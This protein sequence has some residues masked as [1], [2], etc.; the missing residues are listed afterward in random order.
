MSAGVAPAL[1][2]LGGRERAAL[3]LPVLTLALL[4]VTIG[5]APEPFVAFAERAAGQLLDPTLYVQAVLG[6]GT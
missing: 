1:S 6:D 5:L 2:G 4:T 3:L